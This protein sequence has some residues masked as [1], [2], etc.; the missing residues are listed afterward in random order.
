ML[1]EDTVLSVAWQLTDD[2][3]RICTLARLILSPSHSALH[4]ARDAKSYVNSPKAAQGYFYH[5][6]AVCENPG[7]LVGMTQLEDWV[8]SFCTLNQLQNTL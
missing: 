2:R 3:T 8:V 7:P 1:Q 6:P 4:V 5:T